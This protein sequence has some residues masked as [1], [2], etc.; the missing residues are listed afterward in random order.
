MLRKENVNISASAVFDDLGFVN[1][2]E[3]EAVSE[4][5]DVERWLAA[6]LR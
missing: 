2:K 6:A 5:F 1:D 3:D 4:A